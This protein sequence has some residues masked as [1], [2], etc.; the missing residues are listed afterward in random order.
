MLKDTTIEIKLRKAEKDT[1][2]SLSSEIVISDKVD[3]HW[4]DSTYWHRQTRIIGESKG[5]HIT[6][7]IQPPEEIDSHSWVLRHYYRGGMMAKLTHDQF[8]FTGI[9]N[10]RP[11]KEILL[12]TEM[13]QLGLPVPKAKAA[14]VTRNG[15]FYRADLLMEKIEASDLVA[16]LSEKNLSDKIWFK[17]GEVIALFHKNGIYHADLNAH[18]IMIDPSDNVWL[19]DFDR[20]EKRTPSIKW[21]RQNLER[22]KRSF[23]KEKDLLQRFYFEDD[24]WLTLI[25]GYQLAM[26]E[27]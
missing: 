9:N 6:W 26:K 4:F 10:T 24:S 22:L 13:Q 18:N 5:R 15:L 1:L 23:I 12:L 7:F 20:C 27:E 8:L 2:L 16:I 17:L 14:R 21:Q 3:C 19:I 11:F 25:N